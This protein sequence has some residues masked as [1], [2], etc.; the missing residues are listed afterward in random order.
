MSTDSSILLP[1]VAKIAAAHLSNTNKATAEIP[2]LLGDIY[3]SLVDAQTGNQSRQARDPAV[4]VKK[5][6][7]PAY[8][9]CLEEGL[10]LKMLKRHLKAEHNLSPDDYRRKWN[11]PPDYP[12]T[13][14][15]YAK[16]RGDLAKAIG[17]GHKRI[18]QKKK[19]DKKS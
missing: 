17:L 10:K 7:T 9:V 1:L 18:P 14:P 19:P 13:A 11:L 3:R 8:I 15:S 16:R 2:H 4:V 5:S 6:I 12:M